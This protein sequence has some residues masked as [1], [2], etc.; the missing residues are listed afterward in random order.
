MIR[1]LTKTLSLHFIN[2][3]VATSQV[4]VCRALTTQS[5]SR[6]KKEQVP[7]PDEGPKRPLTSY[8]LFFMEHLQKFK[9]EMPGKPTTEFAKKAGEMWS[10]LSEEKKKPYYEKYARERQKYEVAHKKWLESMTS[11]DIIRQNALRKAHNKK[12]M[13]DPTY[14]KRAVSPYIVFSTSL[15]A[16]PPVAKM[17]DVKERV[18]YIAEEWRKL[19][20]EEKKV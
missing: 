10:S 5:S 1:Q 3:R 20:P 7:K 11:L 12:P 15:Q 18:R 13:K 17:Q 14:P 6:T 8:G 19:S 9:D 2:P 4:T 16:K